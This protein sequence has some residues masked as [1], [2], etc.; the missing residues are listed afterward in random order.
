MSGAGYPGLSDAGPPEASVLV[1]EL[2]ANFFAD[3]L[4]SAPDGAA[5]KFDSATRLYL[6]EH[7]LPTLVPA[8]AHLSKAM[9]RAHRDAQAGHDVVHICPT[10]WLAQYLFRHNPRHASDADGVFPAGPM[11]QH[12]SNL[13]A[14]AKSAD[15][16][17]ANGAV[18]DTNKAEEKQ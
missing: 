2:T 5:T 13:A 8:L 4:A 6:A 17:A 18:D 9:E 12:L 11:G 1:A 15:A 10:D 3:M 16:D 14:E 7:V